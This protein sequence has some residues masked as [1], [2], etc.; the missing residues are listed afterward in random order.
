MYTHMQ[1]VFVLQVLE[2]LIHTHAQKRKPALKYSLRKKKYVIKN[3]SA[4]ERGVI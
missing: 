1:G 2:R 4:V 3:L